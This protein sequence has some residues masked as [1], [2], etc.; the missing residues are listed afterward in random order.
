LL[1]DALI[2]LASERGF[3]SV[4]VGELA[5]RAQVNRA[6]FYRHY[7]DKYDLVERIFQQAIEMLRSDLG[8]PGQ[9]A[10]NTDPQNP[11]ER[12]IKLFG[13]FAEHRRLYSAL[14]GRHGS[15]WFVSRMR[16]QIINFMEEREQLRDRIPALRHSP[17][18]TKV[19]TK[20]AVTLMSTLLISTV[21]WWLERGSEYSPEQIASWF[22]EIAINGYVH[23]LGL[24]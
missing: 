12:W 6:T 13:H 8:P 22:L 16:D 20:V 11:P 4:T 9:D 18:Q 24:R 5:E 1:Q 2:E 14:L 21:A 19:P 7:Q 15:T 3:D 10:L 17:R 23:V